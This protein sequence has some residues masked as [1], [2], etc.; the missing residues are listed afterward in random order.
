MRFIATLLVLIGLAMPA[1]A[2]TEV[3]LA[4][5]QDNT[6]YEDND[7]DT[8]NGAGQYL[9]IGQTN[10][11]DLRRALLKFDVASGVPAGAT[12]ESVTL[13][14][15]VSKLPSGS[16]TQ[17]ATL[18]R[19]TSAWGEGTSDAGGNEGGGTAAVAGDA[20]WTHRFFETDTWTTA[21]GDFDAS[22]SASASIGSNGP[23]SWGSTSALVADVQG[24]LDDPDTN[25]GWLIRGNES[26]TRTARR[27]DSRQNAT[28]ANRPVLTIT[29]TQ[30]T[31]A[32][33]T[34][35]AASFRLDGAYP[36]P[37][38]ERT[39]IGYALERPAHVTLEVFDL[40]GR[41]VARLVDAPQTV[42]AHRAAFEAAGLAEGWYGYRLVADGTVAH[43][44][45]LLV[46]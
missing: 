12:I 7:G 28:E 23:V 45:I 1:S 16:G 10:Q 19:V 9:F 37:F 31:A 22:S 2:Q 17:P 43:G 13:S 46:R 24:W 44:R 27:L 29:Y 6:L 15:N 18:H 35:D 39:T 42:G 40:L 26:T 33:E 32:E 21:G 11:G 36:N 5:T 41:R 38:Q 3:T 8:S 34:P 14:A 25:H 4:A 30:A 20:T